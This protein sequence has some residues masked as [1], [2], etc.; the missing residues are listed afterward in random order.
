M[1]N[2]WGNQKLYDLTIEFKETNKEAVIIYDRIGFR[3]VE[4]IESDLSSNMEIIQIFPFF[5]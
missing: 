5:L 2:G 3:T 4:L 1:P